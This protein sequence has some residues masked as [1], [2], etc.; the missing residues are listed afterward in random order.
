MH[1]AEPLVTLATREP[2][3]LVLCWPEKTTAYEAVNKLRAWK[4]QLLKH[5]DKGCVVA[6]TAERQDVLFLL[7][8]AIA[9]AGVLPAPLNARWS[10]T[11]IRT[12]CAA[13]GANAIVHDGSFT[14]HL[15]NDVETAV[16]QLPSSPVCESDAASAITCDF[17]EHCPDVSLICFTSGTSNGMPKGVTISHTGIT[18][19]SLSKCA[20][21]GVSQGCTA[22]AI[23]PMFHIGGLSFAHAAI[24]AGATLALPLSYRLNESAHALR[25]C[26]HITAVSLTP[27]ALSGLLGNVSAPNVRTALLGGGTASDLV[28]QNAQTV[29]P[30]AHVLCA[31]GMTEA[32]SS[33]TFGIKA[34]SPVHTASALP[35]STICENTNS[36][37]KP[38][39]AVGVRL[40]QTTGEIIVSGQQISPGYWSS[41]GTVQRWNNELHTGDIGQWSQEGELLL[42]G[43]LKD[44]IRSGGEN[45]QAAEVEEVLSHV[46]KTDHL[47]AIPVPLDGGLEETVGLLIS[48]H[49]PM[50]LSNHADPREVRKA[51]AS[52]G[53]ASFKTPRV[54]AVTNEPLPKNTGGK[55]DK[56]QALKLLLACPRCYFDDRM[57]LRIS[58]KADD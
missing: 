8:L 12:A 54:I 45:V 5:V 2:D 53:L 11:E 33:I 10:I 40:D 48:T 20:C 30:S 37:G 1:I 15:S 38:A 35:A 26:N 23:V 56:R 32:A 44:I 21:A 9:S 42:K 39:P 47:T 34:V 17:V 3:T 19:A 36:A 22:L 43:R 49:N 55:I 31:Y 46:L 29:F 27:S 16:V 24:L 28:V 18:S 13:I 50:Q 51:C 58:S 4:E 14:T 6:V 7:V 41:K 25:A 57:S 52:Q